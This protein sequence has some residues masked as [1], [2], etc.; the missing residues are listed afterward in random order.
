ML[1][2][3]RG[4]CRP[5][6]A[7]LWPGGVNFAVFSRHA[8]AVSLLLYDEADGPTELPL[9]PTVNRTGDVWH[10]FVRGVPPGTLYGFRVNGPFAPRQGHRFNPRA[11][12]LD[13]YARS[14]SGPYPWGTNH[15]RPD[16]PVRLGRVIA[17]DFDWEDDRPPRTPL[18]HTVVYELHLR[19]YTKHPSSGVSAP[20]TYLG[21]IE[22]I[23]HLK[24]LGTTAVQILPLMEFDEGDG[25][26]KHPTTNQPLYNLWGYSPLSY[27]ALKG[28]YALD[29]GQERREFKQLVKALHAA[30]IEVIL[31]VVYNHTGE[32][33]ENGPAISFRGLDNAVYYLLDEQGRFLDYTGCGNTLNVAHPVVR[34]LILDSMV[35]MVAEYRVDG[36]RFDLGA[37]MVRG[38]DGEPE[39]WPALVR[40]IAEHP[41]LSGC[42]LL[43]EAWDAKGLYILG[44][45]PSWGRWVEF[46]GRFRD[47]VRRWMRSEPNA[48]LELAKR[49]S[50]SLDF[51]GEAHH[52]WHSLNYITCHDGFTLYDLVSYT[53]KRNEANGENNRDGWDHN[54]SFN[55]GDEGPT[56]SPGV[57]ALR[58]RQM[59]NFLTVLMLS[60][61]V[62]FLTAGDEFARTQGGN[63]NPYCQDNEIS[64][65]DWSLAQKHAGLVRFTSMLIAYRKKYFAMEREAFVART[66]W[67]GKVLGEP[68]WAGESRTLALHIAPA[69]GQPQFHVLFNAHWEPQRFAL[70]PDVRWRRLIDTSLP[71]PDD[72]SEERNAVP[73]DPQGTYGTSPRSMVVLI[74]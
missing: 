48:A 27:F 50:G 17:D 31:D 45:F 37:V 36:F 61:G 8:H 44:Q 22:K 16:R 57:E 39:A 18:S 24:A 9:D 70:P 53:R 40:A 52:A 4:H 71:S 60:Q 28:S 11:V 3:S 20:G 32:G 7:T 41:V 73:L 65:V 66:R 56:M 15:Q 25:E 23:P 29:P 58:Q 55:C 43:T 63:N 47:D 19:G 69:M 5:L 10:A 12:L 14:L 1:A 30:G 72:V 13:P 6:G 42:K 26:R 35:E 68:D 49:V 51:Y 21:L 62:P 2:V 74:G 59:R 38:E 64:W 46:N 34:Q 67:H 33:N 54:F